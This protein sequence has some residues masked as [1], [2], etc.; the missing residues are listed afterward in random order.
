[1]NQKL[2]HLLSLLGGGRSEIL[3]QEAFVRKHLGG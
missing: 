1:M 3:P 2:K